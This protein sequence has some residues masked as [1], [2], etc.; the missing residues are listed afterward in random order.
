[1]E[2]RAAKALIKQPG[3]EAPIHA[4]IHMD[5]LLQIRL[6]RSLVTRE[7]TRFGSNTQ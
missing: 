1:M 2:G 3:G 7:R 6:L 4:A 5:K